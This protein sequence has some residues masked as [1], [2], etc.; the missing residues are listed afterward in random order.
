MNRSNQ[1]TIAAYKEAAIE[2]EDENV[3]ADV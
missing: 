3:D 1:I 2:D